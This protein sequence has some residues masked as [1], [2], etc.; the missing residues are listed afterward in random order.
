MYFIIPLNPAPCERPRVGNGRAYNS[1][2]YQAYKDEAVLHLRT[3][4]N[5][6]ERLKATGVRGSK[7][8]LKLWARFERKDRRKV[9]L[10]NLVK[11]LCDVLQDAEYIENDAQIVQMD[12]ILTR[13]ATKKPR[14][15]FDLE[16][17]E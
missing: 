9:D 4:A 8:P 15:V 10:D 5:C 3:C 11:A 14:T 7:A 1:A 6:L 17:I 12:L 13:G 2:R 16:T